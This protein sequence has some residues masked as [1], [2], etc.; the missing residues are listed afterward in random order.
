MTYVVQRDVV[1]GAFPYNDLSLFRRRLLYDTS[2]LF[3]STYKLFQTVKMQRLLLTVLVCL[4]CSPLV[5]M[6]PVNQLSSQAN[7]G[8]WPGSADS[9]LTRRQS[10][11]R[12]EAR[13]NV[14][15]RMLQLYSQ[16]TSQL[17]TDDVTVRS[18]YSQSLLFVRFVLFSSVLYST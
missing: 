17:S 7:R 18:F 15:E 14:P 5:S 9:L 4:S 6:S 2:L 3:V 12:P 8:P 11:R 13:R 10:A 1:V 16:M